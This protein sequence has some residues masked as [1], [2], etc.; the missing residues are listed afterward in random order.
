MQ[1]GKAVTDLRMRISPEQAPLCMFSSNRP[2]S[3]LPIVIVS[4]ATPSCFTYANKPE[5]VL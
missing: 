5:R 1:T 4:S 3:R 2:I